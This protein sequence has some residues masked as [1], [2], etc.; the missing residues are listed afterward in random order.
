MKNIN[1]MNIGR[2]L[3][4]LGFGLGLGSVGATWTHIGDEMYLLTS[5]SPVDVTHSWY[6]FF[7]EVFGDLGAMIGVC[8]LLWAP[9]KLR[10]PLTWWTMLVLL[11]GFYAPFW[12]GAPFMQ[13]LAAPDWIAELQHVVMA[14]PPLVGLFLVRR[15]YF[16]RSF[17]GIA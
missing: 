7:R 6:H 12:V 3:T 1:R 11:A 10:A 15:E 2:A 9:A 4:I 8:I 5:E 16:R 14:V 13:A 17:E